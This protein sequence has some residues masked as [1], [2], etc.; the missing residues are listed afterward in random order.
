MIN[1]PAFI[2]STGRTGTQFFE[3]YINGTSENTM[4]LHEPK[5]SRRFKFLSNMY[6]QKKVHPKTICYIFKQSRKKIGKRAGGNNYVESS[7]FIFGC[8]PALNTCMDDIKVLH[9]I[10]DPYTYVVSHLN[11]GFWRGHK[12][13]FAKHVRYWV[14]GLDMDRRS[15]NDPVKVL[16]ERWVY[17]NR[18]IESYAESNHYLVVRFEDLFSKDQNT[19]LPALNNIRDFLELQ[20]LEGSENEKWLT[21]R[22]NIS[23]RKDNK[24]LL[25]DE[26]KSEFIK[27]HVEIL[28]KYGYPTNPH[29][30]R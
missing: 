5:P 4:C 19:S 26:H 9:I 17:V 20:P 27:K 22:K 16:L 8:I 21:K 14:E 3:D 28:T 25:T 7:N 2:L 12:K 23:K 13:F 1:K 15:K 24:Y 30:S 18:Q 11:K 6:L 29:S 10:R